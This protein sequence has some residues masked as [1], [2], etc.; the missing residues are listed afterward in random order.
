MREVKFR[1][2]DGKKM[3]YDPMMKVIGQKWCSLN[4]HLKDDTTL[5]QQ[6]GLKDKNGVEIYEGDVIKFPNA[7]MI[8]GEICWDE[9]GFWAVKWNKYGKHNNELY[10]LL[11]G[12]EKIEYAGNIHESPELLKG[13]G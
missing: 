11:F 4:D 9:R 13:E 1:A 12:L 7:K 10:L 6:T 3:D 2:W 8:K 5:M